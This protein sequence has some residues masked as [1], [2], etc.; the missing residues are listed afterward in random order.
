M[1]EAQLT[2]AL[3]QMLGV[4]EKLILAVSLQEKQIIQLRADAERAND[5][6]QQFH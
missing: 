1:N 6:H 2:V 3:A 4:M 5:P